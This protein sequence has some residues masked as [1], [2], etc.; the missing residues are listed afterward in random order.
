MKEINDMNEDQ[1]NQLNLEIVEEFISLKDKKNKLNETFESNQNSENL[2]FD[3]SSRGASLEQMFPENI[4]IKKIKKGEKFADHFIKI[5]G[6]INPHHFMNEL[7]DK[8]KGKYEDCF[9]N[10]SKEKLKF[11]VNFEIEQEQEYETDIELDDT[12]NSCMIKIKMYEDEE[13]GY[14]VNFIKKKGDI[15]NYYKLFLEI[16]NIIKNILN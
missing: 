3:I 10:V 6:D 14:F 16:K 1:L 11:E 2:D 9:V 8:I 7:L 15:E 13:G 5:K 4:E 12:D